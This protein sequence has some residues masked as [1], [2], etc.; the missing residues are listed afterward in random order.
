M[1]L[2]LSIVIVNWDT[3]TLLEESLN[4]IIDF[5]NFYF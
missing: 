3:A 2:D 1:N 4:P 5:T